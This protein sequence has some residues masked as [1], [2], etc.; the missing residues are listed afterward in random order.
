DSPLGGPDPGRADAWPGGLRG[1]HRG[2][3]PALAGAGQ[4]CDQASQ[5]IRD[6][7]SARISGPLPGLGGLAKGGHPGRP[8]L[9]ARAGRDGVLY[10]L[11]TRATGLPVHLEAGCA[12]IVLLLALLIGSLSGLIALRKIR[13]AD[14]ADLF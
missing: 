9:P 3:D 4:R 11:T 14:P 5:G 8:R 2:H 13:S 7:E 12:A 1:L 10:A 6:V